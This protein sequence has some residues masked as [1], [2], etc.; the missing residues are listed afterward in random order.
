MI[1]KVFVGDLAITDLN[2]SCPAIAITEIK[3]AFSLCQKCYH[4]LM[5]IGTSQ[6]QGNPINV[7]GILR[8][9]KDSTSKKKSNYITV[10]IKEEIIPIS[11]KQTFIV[12]NFVSTKFT[13]WK[14]TVSIS[15]YYLPHKVEQYPTYIVFNKP[16]D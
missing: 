15:S 7:R 12:S 10:N 4:F 8:R 2:Q 9:L 14:S 13:F 16:L 5:A 6:I 3:V 11:S 1:Y